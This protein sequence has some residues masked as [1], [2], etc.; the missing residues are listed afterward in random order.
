MVSQNNRE[1]RKRK[2]LYST[3]IEFNLDIIQNIGYILMMTYH[4][5]SDYK[6]NDI[7]ALKENIKKL[8]N[9]PLDPLSDFYNFYGPQKLNPDR[10]KNYKIL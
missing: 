9:E 7:E 2:W 4:K 3:I 8:A 5:F 1:K 10:F 6:V